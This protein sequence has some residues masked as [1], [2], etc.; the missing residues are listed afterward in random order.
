MRIHRVAHLFHGLARQPCLGFGGH[1][2]SGGM[3]RYR[4]R[5]PLYHQ[6][7][8]MRMRARF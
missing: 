1:L 2:V 8:V 6:P 7:C 4:A 3:A 5:C